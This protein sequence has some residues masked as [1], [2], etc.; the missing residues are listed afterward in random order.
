MAR[1]RS[2]S[3]TVPMD[4]SWEPAPG[5]LAGLQL[6]TGRLV[7][8]IGRGSTAVVYRGLLADGSEAAYK[9]RNAESAEGQNLDEIRGLVQAKVG[10]HAASL[11]P[12]ICPL[13]PLVHNGKTL[14]LGRD[15]PM[16]TGAIHRFHGYQP[17]ARS[18]ARVERGSD[19]GGGPPCSGMGAS[20]HQTR[21]RRHEPRESLA[22]RLRRVGEGRRA[23]PA[24]DD[25]H[26]R[27]ARAFERYGPRRNGP[28]HEVPRS[29]R[30][31]IHGPGGPAGQKQMQGRVNSETRPSHVGRTATR[32]ARPPTGG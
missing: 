1:E 29:V 5:D 27:C 11:F 16:R 19:S 22:D 10:P 17:K 12:Y 25:A 30:V 4:E 28:S 14:L 21:Q 13:P 18:S 8:E 2:C 7:E 23:V 32:S 6:E 24:V 31:R 15:G 26:V 20:R 9:L 3:P